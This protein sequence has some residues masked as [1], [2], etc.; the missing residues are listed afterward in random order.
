[1]LIT[2]ELDSQRML[3]M[4]EYVTNL[5]NKPGLVSPQCTVEY[6][7]L[8]MVNHGVRYNGNVHRMTNVII[9]MCLTLTITPIT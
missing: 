7:T 4:T 5:F 9:I 1:M 6:I 2:D 8:K 3:R